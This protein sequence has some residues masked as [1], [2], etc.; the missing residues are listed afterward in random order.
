M[1]YG[2]YK[3]QQIK[4]EQKQK[5]QSK[6]KELKNIR[7]SARIEDHDFN[8]KV[9]KAEKFLTKGHKVKVILILKGREAAYMD[10]G[11]ELI[12]EFANSLEKVYK[13]KEKP[14]R[15][16]NTIQIILTPKR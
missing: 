12:N 1:D 9:K 4:K 3:Y 8:I 16:K 14:T 2:K 6:Q 15:E 5:K 11:F 10:R 7:L 13:D